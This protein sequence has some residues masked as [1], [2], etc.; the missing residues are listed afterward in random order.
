MTNEGPP[1]FPN[2]LHVLPF[3]VE[4][5]LVLPA[6]NRIECGQEVH[7]IEPKVMQV[8]ACL[9]ARPSEVI[10]RQTLFDFVWADSVVCE[11][12]LTR[13][14]SEVRR[15]FHDDS[16]TPRVIETI[17]KS[18]YRLIVPVT[19]ASGLRQDPPSHE[20]SPP[21]SDSAPQADPPP[22]SDPAPPFIPSS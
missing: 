5:C 21:Q 4:D 14:I 1:D 12:A 17:R 2:P 20:D 18:G 22:R 15:V 3:R 11:D 7:Q 13:T 9:A 10:S 8:L 16:K 19:P 6:L